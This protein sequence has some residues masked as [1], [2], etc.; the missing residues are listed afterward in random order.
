LL[1]CNEIIVLTSKEKKLIELLLSQKS[2]IFTYDEIFEYVW[3]YNEI[4]SLS[5]L[6]NLI[7]RLRKKLPENMIINLFNEGYKINF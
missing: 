3:G 5:G 2:R 7:T 4:G 6:K 1:Y